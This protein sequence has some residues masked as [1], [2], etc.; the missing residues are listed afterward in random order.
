LLRR[1]NGGRR[2]YGGGGSVEDLSRAAQQGR[3]VLSRDGKRFI[4]LSAGHLGSLPID[5]GLFLIA[6]RTPLDRRMT[7]ALGYA[8]FFGRNGN[9]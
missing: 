3:Y 2:S 9:E 6:L 1:S 7:A 4:T 8:S 5:A